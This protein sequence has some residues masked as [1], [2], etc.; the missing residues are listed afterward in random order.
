M[1]NE[2]AL[3]EVT[4]YH[5]K[6]KMK[7]SL[8]IL[9]SDVQANTRFIQHAFDNDGFTSC[10]SLNIMVTSSQQSVRSHN[11]WAYLST[12]DCSLSFNT[13]VSKVF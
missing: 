3:R 6:L 13:K 10:S 11:M 2:Y 9:K 12:F 4:K 7:N 5:F 1:P 8:N